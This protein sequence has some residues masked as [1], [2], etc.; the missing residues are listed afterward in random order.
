M[1]FDPRESRGDGRFPGVATCGLALAVTVAAACGD[2]GTT[3]PGPD[4]DPPNRPPV[5]T[6]SIP[7]QTVTAG[8]TI[9]IDVSGYFDDPDGDALTYT[10]ETS[11]ANVVTAS[12]AGSSVVVA[13]LARGTA[14]VTVTARDPGG[15]AAQQSFP[16]TV[17]NRS[18]IGVGTITDQELKPGDTVT[19]DVSAYFNDPDGDT[20]SYEATSSDEGVATATISGNSLT[21]A[22]VSD[23]AATVTITARDPDGA[24]VE[25]GLAV[26]VETPGVPVA[27]LAAVSAAAPEG[28]M[29]VLEV[30][31]SPSPESPI[32]VNYAVGTDDDAGTDDADGADYAGGTSGTVRI[33]PGATVAAIEIAITDDDDIEPTREVFTV[34]LEAPGAEA[35]YVL[36]S[37]TSVAVKIM[38][39]VCDRTPQVRDEI[40]KVAGAGECAD[41]EDSD[42]AA[43]ENLDLRPEGSRAGDPVTS[44]SDQRPAALVTRAPVAPPEPNAPISRNAASRELIV[45]LRA[46]DFSGLS[47]LEGLWLSDNELT[48][49]P[50]DVFADLS[51]LRILALGFNQLTELESGM[52]SDLPLLEGLGLSGNGFTTLSAGV[53]SSLDSLKELYLADNRLTELETGTFSNVAGLE[54]LNLDENQLIALQSGALA[55]LHSL[56]ALSL[57]ENQ[58][59]ELQPEVFSDLSRL[60][61]LWLKGNRLTNLERGT[62]SSLTSLGEL[63]LSENPLTELRSGVFSDLA[64]L[65]VLWLGGCELTRLSPGVFHGL[66][67]LRKLGL[68]ENQLTVLARTTLTG[69]AD[70]EE[71]WLDQNQLAELSHDAFSDLPNLKRLVAWGNRLTELP[72]GV[73]SNLSSLEELSL[74]NNEIAGLPAGVFSDLENLRDLHLY[75]NQLTELPPGVFAGL[76]QLIQLGLADNPGSPFTLTLEFE[77]KDTKSLSAPGPA[78]VVLRLAEGAPFAMQVPL[79]VRRGELSADTAVLETGRETSQEFT[80]TLDASSQTGTEVVVGSLPEVPATITGI[81]LAAGDTLLLFTAS[82]DASHDEPD[83]AVR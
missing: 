70:L 33:D 82:G 16:V 27:A 43:I 26:N 36:G 77:R 63:I 22:A 12:A 20:L 51:S 40:F 30:V 9:T 5:A 72:P 44:G 60:E 78:K 56:T 31:V 4:P 6:G 11:D 49:L 35:G 76:F 32:M 62:F 25:Q 10:A 24:S 80:V 75:S 64:R 19:V 53:F 13:G 54:L 65:E 67:R 37:P 69:L 59:A 21:I 66:A 46:M 47:G 14:M 28:G 71:L 83:M 34:V 73:F 45:A 38:E 50:T 29:A 17:P 58:L 3:T 42:L 61:Q 23:G 15:L 52:F 39:G 41:V 18:P 48:G 8:Q 1:V 81:E 68:G 7:P 74:T 57:S 79:S 2:G 55:G